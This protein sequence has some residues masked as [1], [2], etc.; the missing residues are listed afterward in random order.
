VRFKE[1]AAQPGYWRSD[2]APLPAWATPRVCQDQ[3][4]R[5]TWTLLHLGFAVRAAHLGFDFPLLSIGADVDVPARKPDI[6]IPPVLL[7]SHRTTL[8]QISIDQGEAICE[9]FSLPVRDPVAVPLE[10]ACTT[11]LRPMY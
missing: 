8:S 9:T 4:G 1:C 6:T 11:C 5:F 7:N 10:F 3:R 2:L